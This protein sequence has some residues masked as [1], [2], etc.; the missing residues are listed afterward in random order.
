MKLQTW[1]KELLELVEMIPEELRP[2]VF[3]S[4]IANLI[5]E[6]I[7]AK[8]EEYMH[9]I[10]TIKNEIAKNIGY[11]ICSQHQIFNDTCKLCGQSQISK[12]DAIYIIDKYAENIEFS[13]NARD[14]FNE[15]IMGEL[16]IADI[17]KK[18][19]NIFPVYYWSSITS[20]LR[21]YDKQ[22]NK[23]D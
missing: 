6:V 10:N 20:L 12:E 17:I 16:Q 19:S 21:D 7:D 8:N 5:D 22:I 2:N 23:K 4:L 11:S 3:Y 9:R 13:R 14:I 15:K 1:R 18:Y